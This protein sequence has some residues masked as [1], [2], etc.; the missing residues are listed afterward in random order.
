MHLPGCDVF[1]YAGHTDV[2]DGRGVLVQHVRAD[3]LDSVGSVPLGAGSAATYT[4]AVT[5][6]PG[7]LESLQ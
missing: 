6:V 5:A 4:E 3:R 1:H 2:V 7:G